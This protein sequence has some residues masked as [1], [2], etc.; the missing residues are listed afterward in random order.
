MQKLFRKLVN[1]ETLT[2]IISGVGV[3]IVN[4]GLFQI[5][6]AIHMDY[7]WANLIAIISA[8]VFAYIMNKWLVFC[9]RSASVSELVKEILRFV[10]AR[11]FTGLLDYFGLILA[12]ELFHFD[13]NISKYLITIVVIAL[14]YL[15][16]KYVVFSKRD[17]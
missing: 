9:N 5:L 12:V 14:N 11:G 7:R 13:Q 10:Y 4:I 2:Y 3:G 8:R 6:T 16:A 1:R 15:L 17:S